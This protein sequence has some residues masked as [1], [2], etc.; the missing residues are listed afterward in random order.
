[1]KSVIN[2]IKQNFFE[3]FFIISFTFF[4]FYKPIV[5]G[6]LMGI[7]VMYFSYK[8][9]FVLRRISNNSKYTTAKIIDY[10]RVEWNYKEPIISFETKEGIKIDSKPAF[11]FATDLSKIRSYKN[12][13]N[14]PVEIIYNQNN[15]N[16]FVIASESKLNYFVLFGIT[17]IGII[18]IVFSI[19]ALLGYVEVNT[20]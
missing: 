1:L 17:M 7:Y 12:K 8:Y 15:P 16:E 2:Y 20:N 5:C 4:A 13:I 9:F 11:Y 6:F 3:V 14:Q 10:K 19:S 18:F